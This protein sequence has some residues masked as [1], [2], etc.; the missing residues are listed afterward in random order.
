MIRP[1]PR[2]TLFPYTTLFDL[3]DRLFGEREDGVL[4]R[5]GRHDLA[6]VAGE[7]RLGEVAR[8][9]HA[10]VEV[11]ELVPPAGPRDAHHVR[12]GFPVLVVAEDHVHVPLYVV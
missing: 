10:D 4:L 6:V 3:A 5:V 12:L 7:V 11:L 9:G 2:S 1:P 8:E